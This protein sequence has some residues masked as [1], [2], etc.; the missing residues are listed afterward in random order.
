MVVE[1]AL[2]EILDIRD[3]HHSIRRWSAVIDELLE[4]ED[5]GV[6]LFNVDPDDRR[7]Y[8][9]IYIGGGASG[10]FG[11][12]YLRA[13]GGR[14]LIIDR[15]PFLGGTCPHNACVPHHLFSECAAELMLQRTFSGRLWF[16]DMTGVVTSIKEVVDVF[17]AGRIGPHAIMNFQ[18]KEQ[19]D[20]EYVLNAEARIVDARTVEVAGRT[21]K[22]KNLVLGMGARP[23]MPDVPGVELTGVHTNV[24]LVET[25]DRDPGPTIVVVGGS[26]TAV[27]YGTFFSSTGRRTIFLCR[28]TLLKNLPD[29]ETRGYVIDRMVEQGVEIRED[30]V[31]E[32][33]HDDGTGRV[34]SVTVRGPG[35][36]ETIATDFVFIGLGEIPNSEVARDA[37]GVEIG[38]KNEV[39]V[40]D[41]LRT[42]VPGVYAIGDLIGAPM[43]MW[44]ARRSGTYAS[45]NIMGEDVAFQP[46]DW[47]DFLH[48]HY[49][50]TW[51]GLGEEEAREKY[52]HVTVIKMPPDTEDGLD[53]GLPASDRQMLYAFLEPRLSGFQKLIID[54][55]SRRVIGAHH[56]GSGAKDGFQYLAVLMRQGLTI[57]QL[58]EMDELFLNPSHFIQLSRLRAGSRTLRDL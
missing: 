14:Q 11:A 22:A 18:S 57:D 41:H 8:D 7:E 17:R 2:P 12:A 50:V 23:Q 53:V 15:F 9:A 40:D 56:V 47:P 5:G 49:E 27:E 26:K 6:P 58:G 55:G 36:R 13:M 46:R 44:K 31:L 34:G 35:G 37:L 29:G 24:S 20:L 42:R 3:E 19:L 51:L 21:F 54:S 38:P 30:S 1:P 48:T 10:R 32:E 43:E 16:P 39:I 52:P 4:S 28:T 45:R 33:I 25:L